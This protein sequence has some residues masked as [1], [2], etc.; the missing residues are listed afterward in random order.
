M[1]RERDE[2]RT[3]LNLRF[4]EVGNLIVVARPDIN[5]LN[6]ALCS[7]FNDYEYSESKCLFSLAR[8]TLAKNT[9]WWIPKEWQWMLRICAIRKLQSA[10]CMPYFRHF[11]VSM[12]FCLS[13][14]KYWQ[15]NLIWM[16]KNWLLGARPRSAGGTVADAN[17]PPDTRPYARFSS[18]TWRERTRFSLWISKY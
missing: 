7:P 13:W 4:P 17:V 3:K 9:P 15:S 12:N 14:T 6:G 8:L 10:P 11:K 1:K 2:K 5:L 18:P 16:P